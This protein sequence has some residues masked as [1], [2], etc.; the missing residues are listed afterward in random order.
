MHIR[1]NEEVDDNSRNHAIG[2]HAKLDTLPN[3]FFNF[4][5]DTN[6]NTYANA[7]P[8]Y[9]ERVDDE[10][11]LAGCSYPNGLLSTL[12]WWDPSTMGASARGTSV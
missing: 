3:T 4:H 9:T 2:R 6:S 12:S 8:R 10:Y 1:P 5:D 7:N 11:S